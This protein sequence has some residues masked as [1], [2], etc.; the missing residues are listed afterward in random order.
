MEDSSPIYQSIG[1]YIHDLRL[2]K[3]VTG[4]SLVRTAGMSQSKLSKIETESIRQP[5][6]EDINRLLDALDATEYQRQQAR[7]LMGQP[8]ANFM[9]SKPV[10]HNFQD[11]FSVETQATEI[12]IFTFIIPALLQTATYQDHVLNR[13][14]LSPSLRSK[15]RRLLQERQDRLWDPN[16]RFT[17]LM[18][19]SA[20]Y[21]AAA[22]YKEQIVQ[23]DRIERMLGVQTLSCGIIPFTA[24]LVADDPCNFVIYNERAGFYEYMGKDVAL[25][26]ITEIH[27][28]KSR[29][30]AFAN[31][32]S[33][34][35]DVLP[36]LERAKQYFRA[37]I[38]SQTASALK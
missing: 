38:D 29:F 23:I 4:I 19:E 7:W 22:G 3:G 14:M 8:R 18:Y 37:R 34:G 25:N 11:C 32:A 9:E 33:F 26:D 20:L 2:Q 31:M 27:F 15:A 28:A 6:A 10:S 24:G 5:R 21:S 16:C 1:H 36:Y 30:E 13:M 17:F 35:A 12:K